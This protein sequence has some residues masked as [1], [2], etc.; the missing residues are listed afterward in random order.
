MKLNRS[1]SL[2]PAILALAT[3]ALAAC[4]RSPSTLRPSRATST[5]HR[6]MTMP[7]GEVH[8]IAKSGYITGSDGRSILIWGLA[9]MDTGQV[10]YPGPT[11]RA[12]QGD[13]IT[14]HLHNELPF[15]VSLDFAGQAMERVPVFD[16]AGVLRSTVAEAAPGG[17]A[18]YT[19]TA[20]RPGTFLYQSGTDVALQLEMGLF[21]ALIVDP[22]E[23]GKAYADATGDSAYDREVL[24]VLSEMDVRIH[25]ALE[26]GAA[27]PPDY[28]PVYWFLNGRGHPDTMADS[29]VPWLPAQPYGA[30]V[31]M[32]PGDRV[33]VR[34]IGAGRDAHPF[35]THGNH[36]RLIAQNGRLLSS[37]P[38]AGA[39]LAREHFTISVAPGET[40][41]AIYTWTGADLGW[42]IY[43]PNHG[44]LPPD[45]ASHYTD[46]RHS[47]G[48]D[49]TT[50]VPPVAALEL[51][52]SY[53]GS[54][55]LGSTADIPPGVPHL[56][57]TGAYY[58]MWHSHNEK[59][60]TS[61]DIF[62]G[63]MMTMVVIEHPSVPLGTMEGGM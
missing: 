22:P 7:A 31:S 35:H 4:E 25:D 44:P 3:L 5:A 42:D 26:V 39:D 15:P 49:F 57:S 60:L 8:L 58:H 43:G 6:G 37:G 27:L 2:K 10:Q 55:Y 63:G 20:T 53:S 41:D 9:P 1:S 29:N 32:H 19:F 36:A 51:G 52:E 50:P 18:I 46:P 62:P 14:V 33:L 54:P 56:D 45:Q 16:G 40:A 23:M 13:V 59:E 17:L 30:M 28:K 24:Y 11:I 38:A 48:I 21:G 34:L 47:H 61:N 12:A